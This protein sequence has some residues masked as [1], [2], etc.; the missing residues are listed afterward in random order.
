MASTGVNGAEE[1]AGGCYWC[2]VEVEGVTP[3]LT[4]QSTA[5]CLLPREAYT[6]LS[7]CTE[8]P[9][10]MT[11]ACVHLPAS[12]DLQI[13]S[14]LPQPPH[15]AALPHLSHHVGATPGPAQPINHSLSSTLPAT[16]TAAVTGDEQ[17]L[18]VAV[19]LCATFLLVIVVLVAVIAVLCW[20]RHWK[21]AAPMASAQAARDTPTTSVSIEM[22]EFLHE[23]MGA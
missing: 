16:T 18:Y 21:R 7:S 6:G 13:T 2:E 11:R 12:T 5:L 22:S 17:G 1:R 9:A 15:A 23:C 19:A 8:D 3:S 14:S 20:R 4:I 10:N